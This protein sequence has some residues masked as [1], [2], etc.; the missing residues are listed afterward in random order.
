VIDSAD[1]KA[2]VARGV[3]FLDLRDPDW[4]KNGDTPNGIRI[5]TLEMGSYACCIL[6]QR[7]GAIN[8]APEDYGAAYDRRLREL[9]IED[10]DDEDRLG[11]NLPSN[12]ADPPNWSYLTECWIEVIRA[13]RNA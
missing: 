7:G 6:G 13:R 11:F 5:E 8:D 9:G 10:E 3:E 1:I 12:F 2:A 4:W